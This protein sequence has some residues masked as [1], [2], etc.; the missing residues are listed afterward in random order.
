M[1]GSRYKRDTLGLISVHGTKVGIFSGWGKGF[2][3][4][5]TGGNPKDS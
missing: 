2:P 4:N 3:L 5:R 1:G